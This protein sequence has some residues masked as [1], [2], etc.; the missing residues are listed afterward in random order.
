MLL[1]ILDFV[2][3]T[4]RQVVQAGDTV[5]D[6]TAGNGYDTLFLASCVGPTGKVVA[7]DIQPAAIVSTRTKLESAGMS[8]WVD[9]IQTGHEHM[10]EYIKSEVSAIMF[11]LGYLPGAD[12]NCTTTAI[13]TLKAMQTGL[14]HLAP[15]GILAVVIY[16]GHEQGKIEAVAVLS[17]AEELPQQQISVLQY[18][19]INRVHNAPF[20]L[21]LQKR[22]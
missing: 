14:A 12:K 1:N 16:P 21:F 13:T 5:I 18:A 10:N 8:D 22:N 9:L 7:F 11:N 4:I 2:H 19:F 20:A 17:W 6:A 3:A 15:G